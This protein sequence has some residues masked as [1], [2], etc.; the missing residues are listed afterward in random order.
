MSDRNNTVLVYVT[1]EGTPASRFDRHYYVHQHLPMV[2]KAWR[3]YGL[4]SVSAFF[5]A[6]EQTGT[7]AL[8]ECR[9]RDE[10][11]VEAAFASHESAAVMADVPR[12]TDLS[13][14]RAR[15]LPL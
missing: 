5:P 2:L 1:Y 3:Q 14:I 11:A 13:P 12:F 10:A 8:C 4:E 15:A 9:F 6:V 7:I